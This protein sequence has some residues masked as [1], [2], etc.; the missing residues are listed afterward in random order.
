MMASWHDRAHLK[1]T[2]G[3]AGKSAPLNMQQPRG[4]IDGGFD[5]AGAM[6]AYPNWLQHEILVLIL[7][8]IAIGL[9]VIAKL[10]TR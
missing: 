5:M 9:I 10:V 8:V 7:T 3:K 2:N 1:L 6:G 4:V